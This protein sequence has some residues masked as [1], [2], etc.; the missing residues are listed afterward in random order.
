MG[1]DDG[2][3]DS[4]IKAGETTPDGRLSL[5]TARCIGACSIAPAVI[6]D[7]K[8]A[9]RQTP[10]AAIEKLANLEPQETAAL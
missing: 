8:V 9:S 10:E 4:L 1:N 6:Y 5:L 7:G 3:C 2:L